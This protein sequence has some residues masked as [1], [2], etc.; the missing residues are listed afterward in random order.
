MVWPARFGIVPRHEA[1][2]L[3][4]CYVGHLL[5]QQAEGWSNLQSLLPSHP[6]SR[7]ECPHKQTKAYTVLPKLYKSCVICSRYCWSDLFSLMSKVALVLL[8]SL[9]AYLWHRLP[10]Q[11]AEGQFPPGMALFPHPTTLP[12]TLLI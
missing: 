12:I 10:L 11:V 6:Q 5:L 4:E 1:D 8:C 7:F 3:W 9:R 2:V